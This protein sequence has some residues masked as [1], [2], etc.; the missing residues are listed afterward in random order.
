MTAVLLKN[1]PPEPSVLFQEEIDDLMLEARNYL[2]GEPIANEEQAIAVS[3]LLSRLRRISNDADE[4]RKLEKKPHDEAGKAVQGKW[5]PILDAA[6]LAASTAKQALAPWLV[7][8]EEA[9]REAASKLRAE[10]ERIA[11]IAQEKVQG[12]S[13]NLEARSDAENLLKAA[14]HTHKEAARADRAKPL[15]K[16]GERSV[17]LVDRFTPELVDSVAALKHYRETQPNELKAWLLEQARQDIRAGKR[18]IPGFT[19]T[20][21][22]VAR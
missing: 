8:V 4:A 15:A 22:R 19:I 13:G 21:E 3:S 16:G 17:G 18:A 12:S 9:Q 10:A 20:T 7:K 11:A 6:D 5:R 14:A 1:T 2:D